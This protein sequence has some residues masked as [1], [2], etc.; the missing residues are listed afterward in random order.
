MNATDNILKYFPLKSQTILT[1]NESDIHDSWT[2]TLNHSKTQ[3]NQMKEQNVLMY[4]KGSFQIGSSNIHHESCLNFRGRDF[5]K[6]VWVYIP[7]YLSK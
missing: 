4:S 1:Y 3:I 2:H 7:K 5:V 6:A